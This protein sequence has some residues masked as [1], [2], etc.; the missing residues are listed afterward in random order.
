MQGKRE[1]KDRIKM[2]AAAG[3]G[4]GSKLVPVLAQNDYDLGKTQSVFERELGGRADREA[5]K[6]E[7]RK[8]LVAGRDYAHE[9]TRAASGRTDARGTVSEPSLNRL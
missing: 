6:V 3:S 8:L 9:A 7:K 5:F 2:V 1:K 4:Y